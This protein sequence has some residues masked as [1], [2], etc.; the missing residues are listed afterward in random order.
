MSSILP[1]HD[2]DRDSVRDMNLDQPSLIVE[3][4]HEPPICVIQAELKTTEIQFAAVIL[5]VLRS[6]ILLMSELVS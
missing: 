6:S 3:W 2:F 5:S 1:S 4:A